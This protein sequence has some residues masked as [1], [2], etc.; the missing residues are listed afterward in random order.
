MD[1]WNTPRMYSLLM[2]ETFLNE[3]DLFNMLEITWEALPNK[4]IIAILFEYIYFYQN[5]FSGMLTCP[6]EEL[7]KIQNQVQRG[8][9]RGWP[10]S[11][12]WRW[13]SRGWCSLWGL[14][15]VVLWVFV[16]PTP[17]ASESLAVLRRTLPISP[18]QRSKT[19]HIV[20]SLYI[21]RL[22]VKSKNL[23]FILFFYVVF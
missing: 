21:L 20:R 13:T 14:R 18:V 17:G 12:Q 2:K 16:A 3:L 11:R 5:R 15:A 1:S 23:D 19:L 4:I 6:W 8:S 10:V 7:A 9:S 22:C